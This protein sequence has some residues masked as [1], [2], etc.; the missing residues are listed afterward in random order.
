MSF[1]I[2]I[3]EMI[4]LLI[5][6]HVHCFSPKI[7]EK[8]IAQ[9][10]ERACL[11]PLTDGLVETTVKRFDEWGVDRGVLLPIATKPTQQVI[12][13]DWAAGN[14]GG[15]F[16][17]FGTVHP[18]AEDICEE[19][20]RIKELGL[21]GIK[22]HHDYQG[23]MVDD[24]CLDAVYDEIERRELPLIM[25]AGFDVFS[26]MKIHCPPERAL[27]MIKK[28]PHLKVILAHL[29]GNDS[30]QQVL[31]IL[32]GTGGEV[33][34][35]TAFTGRFVTDGLM[36]DI[37]KKHGADR[38]LFASDCPWD[39]PLEIK[40]KILRLG[41]SDDEREMIFSGNAVRLLGL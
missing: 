11:E 5:D 39:S 13:N 40:K 16:I 33:Y 7:A 18:D 37:I 17:S 4:P 12:L 21:Y 29:G 24:E 10:K 14:N 8:A 38:I 41:I 32:A 31:D 9:L 28:H 3:P 34:F 6:F 2:N 30:S 36:E 20:D 22:L 1:T 26:P 35:D 23:H 19:L 15:R 25:H 27:K